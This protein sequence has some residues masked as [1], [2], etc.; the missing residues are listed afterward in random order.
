MEDRE[1]GANEREG[2][3]GMDVECEGGSVEKDLILIGKEF[4]RQG[5]ELWKERSEHLSL[6]VRDARERQ[7]WSEE[8]V[9]PVGLILM[10]LRR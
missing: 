7:R 8:P 6:D 1:S 3:D 2:R 9:L 4:Q 10:R 5:K